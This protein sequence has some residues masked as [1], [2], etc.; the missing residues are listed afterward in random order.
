MSGGCRASEGQRQNEDHGHGGG[1]CLLP[2]EGPQR[3]LPSAGEPGGGLS[4][5]GGEG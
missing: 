1:G 3:A 5:A 2:T 4:E